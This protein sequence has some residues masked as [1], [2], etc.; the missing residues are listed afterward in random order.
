MR[1]MVFC[2][3]RR[4]ICGTGMVLGSALA[5]GQS[6]PELESFAQSSAPAI[7]LA[8]AQVLQQR[9][10]LDEVQA[11]RGPRWIVGAS[12]SDV[13]EPAS[14]TA[15]NGYRRASAQVGLRWP[16]FDSAMAQDRALLD[17]QTA[18]TSA[19]LRARQAEI[20][21]VRELRIAY[22]DHL[23]STRRAELSRALLKQE[24]SVREVLSARTGRSLL[25]EADR[26]ELV[27]SFELGRR[28]EMRAT[29]QRNE[30]LLRVRRLSG[31]QAA[32]PDMVAP[33]WDLHC[34]C[35][36]ALQTGTDERPQV[37]A[38]AN[39]V[40]HRRELA[41]QQHSSAEGGIALARNISRDFG[42]L[43]GRSIA[44]AV[45]V[46]VP[47][48]WRGLRDARQAHAQGELDRASMEL[49]EARALDRA[50]VERAWQDVEVRMTDHRAALSRVDAARE[51]L[52]VAIQ[53]EQRLGGDVFE[54]RIRAQHDL[55]VVA[56][57]ISEAEQRLASAQANLLSFVQPC[58]PSS[59][60]SAES[61]LQWERLLGEVAQAAPLSLGATVTADARETQVNRESVG[62]P[63][64]SA[65]VVLPGGKNATGL[66]W[67]VW[68]A[69][70]WLG[71]PQAALDQ[72]PPETD[73]ILVGLDASQMRELANPAGS[74]SL[75]TLVQ[76]AHARNVRVHLLLGDP[77]W[78]LPAGRAQL[79]ALLRPL[80]HLPFD[81]L[82]LDLERSQLAA[83]QQRLWTGGTVK[84]I[85]AVRSFWTLPIALVTHDRDLVDAKF[86]AR[87]KRSGVSEL[88]PMI[89]VANRQDALRRMQRVVRA[90]A[91]LKVS[92]AQSVE[93]ELPASS[94]LHAAG[95][96]QAL[97]HVQ[98]LA[99][100]LRRA[101]P[102]ASGQT[103]RIGG[104][105]LQSF[106]DFLAAAP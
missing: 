20:D 41:Q 64:E 98:V 22:I 27:S 37:L 105:L 71:D 82:F 47:F 28:D 32:V 103:P 13:R 23:Y 49:Q 10:R 38:A 5:L 34:R 1:D 51:A 17:A 11:L 56:V 70:P 35:L 44:L 33:S 80:S 83:A 9:H 57:E 86:S 99:S 61:S 62:A 88:V 2:V 31:Q 45:E 81:G 6:L 102:V 8:Q 90:S 106:E 73:R 104:V 87:L 14:T 39:A 24:R 19:S 42:G 16:L 79:L 15:L 65:D 74:R 55:Y 77:A 96:A 59:E 92:I 4:W 58:E 40:A 75:R 69:A 50:A 36:D 53:R 91:G 76:E 30:A 52:R 25:L 95:R 46:S 7:R 48:D 85:A 84:T 67:F 21:V 43:S 26:R 66:G 89:Y 93:R 54:R 12:V 60:K 18:W 78:I 94:S 29:A 63:P 68:R 3:A 72:L 101:F 100:D 97:R